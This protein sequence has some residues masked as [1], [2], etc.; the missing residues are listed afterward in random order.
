MREH[1]GGCLCGAVRYVVRGPLREILVC[2]CVN[3]RRLTGRAW[4]AT[5]AQRADLEVAG[6]VAWTPSPGSPWDARRGFC[7]ACG[8]ALFWDA[9]CRPTVSIGAG[10]LDDPGG[11]CVA[12]HVH[13]ADAVS[14][15]APADG[16]PTFPA[17][18]PD[19]APR[20]RWT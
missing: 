9:P 18:Y 2:H 3:C 20:P 4:P 14:W 12:A 10:T 17:G 6:D 11:L 13:A 1:L 19:D 15:D 5:A 16:V 8:T 7:P